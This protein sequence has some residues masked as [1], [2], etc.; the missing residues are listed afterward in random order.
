ME[1]AL[2]SDSGERRNLALDACNRALSERTFGTVSNQL[3]VFGGEP[4]YWTPS[5]WGELF[6]A[7]RQVWKLV[8]E[9]IDD[10][11]TQDQEKASDILIQHV[12]NLGVI[13][14]LADMI[15]SD[16]SSLASKSYVDDRKIIKAVNQLLHSRKDVPPEIREKWVHVNNKL[17]D[18]DYHSS[19]KR[20]VSMNLIEDHFDDTGNRTKRLQTKIQELAGE[21]FNQLELFRKELP[22]LVTT[23]ASNGYWF[24]YYLAQNDKDFSLI[25]QLIDAQ[26]KAKENATLYFLGGYLRTLFEEN[27]LA[28]ED[29]MD[30]LAQEPETSIWIFELTQRTG[31]LT[32]RG[33]KRILSVL[34]ENQIDLWLVQSFMYGG[35]F[36]N[37]PKEAFNE[38][39]EFLISHT[40]PSAPYIALGLFSSFYIR[41]GT[42]KSL[43]EE[44]TLQLLTNEAFSEIPEGFRQGNNRVMAPYHWKLIADTYISSYPDNSLKISASALEYFNNYE[45]IHDDSAPRSVLRAIVAKYPKEV[46]EQMISYLGVSFAEK[47]T[48]WLRGDDF[49]GQPREEDEPVLPLIP[50]DIVWQWVED[51]VEKRAPYLARFIPPVL[52][53]DSTHL[54]WMRELLIRYGRLEEVRGNLW[55]NYSTEGW[56]GNESE[57]LERKKQKLFSLRHNETNENVKQW[58]DDYIDSLEKRTMHVRIEE[59]RRDYL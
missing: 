11:P 15:A 4:D 12:R 3:Q 34:Q 49:F 2:Q 30:E 9:T 50:K 35:V 28:W 26:K 36:N 31:Q 14:D 46:W 57:H 18:D 25:P 7:Y 8:L 40:A 51:D 41:E 42:T 43:P 24:G 16:M 23:E 38:L 59:E 22:W 6:G 58:L 54:S 52:D 56:M 27:A 32:K 44:L 21:S 20:Y 55:S 1:E 39:V 19:M 10:L 5:S 33:V 45:T 37:L 29:L 53:P 47:L 13:P 48:H 17:L